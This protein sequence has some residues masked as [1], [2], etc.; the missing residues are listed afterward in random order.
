MPP[1]NPISQVLQK[2]NNYSDKWYHSFPFVLKTGNRVWIA[3]NDL[4]VLYQYFVQRK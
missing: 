4:I 2:P 1:N 3:R